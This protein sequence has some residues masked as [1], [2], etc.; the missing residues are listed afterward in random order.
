MKPGTRPAD[1]ALGF[2]VL[3]LLMVLALH[4]PPALPQRVFAQPV[5]GLETLRSGEST[6]EHLRFYVGGDR[7]A[8]Y[9]ESD[10]TLRIE[11]TA[12]PDLRVCMRDDCRTVDGWLGK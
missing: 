8:T 2:A 4:R 12:R 1:L 5:Q 9:T 10:H 7:I 11:K 3:V 6:Y